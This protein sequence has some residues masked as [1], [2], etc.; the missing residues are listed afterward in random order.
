MYC[1]KCKK[2]TDSIQVQETTTRNNRRR[3]TAICQLCGSKKS[4]F[5]TSKTG[6]GVFNN[7]LS[8]VGNVVGEMHLPAKQGEYVP[9]GSF[10]NQNK[11][12]FCGP[13]TKYEQRN[14]EGYQGINDLDKACKL[15]D[16]FY[17]ENPDTKSRNISDLALAHRA[18][19]I[20]K[21]PSFDDDQRWWAD[22][23]S[24]TMGVKAKLGL[25][26]SKNSKRGPTNTRK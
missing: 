24:R 14:R 3:L 26:H 7:L 21:D 9:G 19:E 18:R 17:N 6:E 5:V 15:H 23:V 16:Q 25:G 10:N 13:G 22:K 20:A 8:A 1:V 11:Y 2:K 12:S 4:Q